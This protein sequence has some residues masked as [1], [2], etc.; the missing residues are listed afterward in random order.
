MKNN[1]DDVEF[2]YS[3]EVIFRLQIVIIVSIAKL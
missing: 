1:N 2:Q 3:I